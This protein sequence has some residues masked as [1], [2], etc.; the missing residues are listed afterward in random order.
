MPIYLDN[1]ATTR[2]C[3]PAVSAVFHNMVEDYGNP[4][5]LHKIGLTAE[6][7]VTEARKA[8]AAALVC[9]PQCITF[10]SGATEC[11]NTAIFGAAKNY[12]KRKKKIVVSA[13]E[14]PSVAEPIKYLEEKEGFQIVRIKPSRGGEISAEDFIEAVDEN[15]CLASCMLVNNETGAIQPVRKIFSQIKRDFPECITHCDAVQGFMKMPIK[16]AEI[17]ADVIVVSGHK[18]HAVKGVGAMYIRK[19]VRIAPLLLGGGQEKNLRSGTESV[20]LIAGFGAA[21]RALMP[22]VGVANENAEKISAY[23]LKKLSKLDYVTVNSTAENS[24]PY[25]INFS[26]EG[27]RS[28]IMLHFLE[29]R[30]I[31]V[32]SGSACAKGA[33]SSVLT[34]MGVSDKL[35]DSA[36]RVSICRTTTM[37]EIDVLVTALQEGWQSLAKSK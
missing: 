25:I 29:S 27:I 11:N 9:D 23:L 33:H 26:V 2:P 19:G 30:D 28:E 22:T 17:F 36:I 15:T 10:T 18:V 3:E 16:S 21:I 37:G 7:N 20:P 31:Y 4:S 12:G 5:S 6:Q 13:I 34:A 8:V 1:A 35:A 14:H 32:S 24:S